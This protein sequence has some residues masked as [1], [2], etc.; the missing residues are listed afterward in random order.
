[1]TKEELIAILDK[2]PAGT[3]IYV[4][5]AD[6]AWPAQ[7][8]RFN[9]DPP[10]IYIDIDHSRLDDHLNFPEGYSGAVEVSV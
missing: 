9:D 8:R 6:N 7:A 10:V 1:M 3:E 4:R 5:S 2:V